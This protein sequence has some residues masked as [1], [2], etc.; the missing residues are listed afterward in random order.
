MLVLDSD[1][2]YA[3]LDSTC[4]F[5]SYA[6]AI[7]VAPRSCFAGDTAMMGYGTSFFWCSASLMCSRDVFD[8][9]Y[10]ELPDFIYPIY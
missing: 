7:N 2:G 6:E 1:T 9:L 8:L 10:F 5:H 3:F 4:P